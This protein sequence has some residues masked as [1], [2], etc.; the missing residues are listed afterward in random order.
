MFKYP[1]VE[2]L[3]KIQILCLALLFVSMSS[4]A[5]EKPK[6]AQDFAVHKT[7]K[8][9]KETLDSES[10]AVLREAA[11]ERAFSGKY[12]DWHEKGIFVCKACGNPLYSSDTKFKSGT[13]WPSFYDYL[14]DKSITK[15]KDNSGGW[16]GVEILCQRC[17]SH[18]G[19]VF[20]D[21]PK[22][23]GLRYCMNSLALKFE[24]R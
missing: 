12:V 8:Q 21:G 19:H 17:G 4:C 14:D 16:S 22:P 1:I 20:E 13:G 24:K 3:K 11:T 10:Y 5:Q 15:V 18:I 2:S 7:E 9:W 6:N 23:T